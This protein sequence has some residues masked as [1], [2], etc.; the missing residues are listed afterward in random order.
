M[1]RNQVSIEPTDV[2]PSLD[3][4]ACDGSGFAHAC[5]ECGG[6]D[7]ASAREGCETCYGLG[8]YGSCPTCAGTGSSA[9]TPHERAAMRILD[10]ILQRKA[11]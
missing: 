7:L 11:H 4:G 8:G 2:N 10:L 1:I 9:A 6:H 5:P 3:C